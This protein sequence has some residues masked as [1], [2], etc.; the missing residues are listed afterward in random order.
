MQHIEAKAKELTQQQA[1]MR[2]AQKK[3]VINWQATKDAVDAKSVA[4]NQVIAL[5]E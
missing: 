2:T 3:S 1:E 5:K 4:E